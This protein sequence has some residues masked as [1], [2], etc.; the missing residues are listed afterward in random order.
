MN[1]ES[2][3]FTPKVEGKRPEKRKVSKGQ[4]PTDNQKYFLERRDIEVPPTK[5]LAGRYIEFIKLGWIGADEGERIEMLKQA[6]ARFRNA[7]IIRNIDGTQWQSVGV[8]PFTREEM[9]DRKDVRERGEII[10]GKKATYEMS[11]FAIRA[12]NKD[13][14]HVVISPYDSRIIEN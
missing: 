1:E 3:K 12:T 2:P 9:R 7:T 10:E 5:K 8:M 6:L 11:W 14:E 13:G 4:M